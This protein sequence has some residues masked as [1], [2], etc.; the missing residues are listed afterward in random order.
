MGELPIDWQRLEQIRQGAVVDSQEAPDRV[1]QSQVAEAMVGSAEGRPG[2]QSVLRCQKPVL[3]A[4][5][6]VLKVQWHWQATRP[7]EPMLRC[8]RSR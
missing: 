1:N 7:E 8:F 6:P 5:H 4:C 3:P 2:L